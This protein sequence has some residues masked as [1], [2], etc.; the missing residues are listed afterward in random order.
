VLA[1]PSGARDN[2]IM[3]PIAKGVTPKDMK[4]VASYLASSWA[5]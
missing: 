2:A 5:N 1:A 3:H 4:A